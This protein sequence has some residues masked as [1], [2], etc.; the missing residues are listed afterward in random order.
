[1]SGSPSADLEYEGVGSQVADD[2]VPSA[3]EV[4]AQAV[5]LVHKADTW[6]TVF[7]S[8]APHSLRLRLHSSHAVEQADRPIE[9]SQRALHLQC[10][11]HVPRSVDDVDPVVL[12]L[13]CG[14]SRSDCDPSLLLLVANFRDRLANH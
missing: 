11:V 1:V 9:H 5:H 4:G 14:G 8:L 13:G 7:V 3:E 6:D 12:P 2:H 10:E